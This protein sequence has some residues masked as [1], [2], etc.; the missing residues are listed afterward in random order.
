[1]PTASA[2]TER[3]CDTE[4]KH[5]KD[6]KKGSSILEAEKDLESGFSLCCG[7]LS[8]TSSSSAPT[9]FPV[10][11]LPASPSLSQPQ[12]HR[13]AAAPFKARALSFKDQIAFYLI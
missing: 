10:I 5:M 8:T 3:P 11:P 9:P 2:A 13:Q 12:V 4:R 6:E 7:V 1:M